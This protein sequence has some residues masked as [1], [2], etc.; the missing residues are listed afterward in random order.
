MLVEGINQFLIACT[1]VVQLLGAPQGRRD[2]TTGFFPGSAPE[3][4]P[5][6]LIVYRE[7]S[8][9]GE[10][11]FD[12]PDGLRYARVELSCQAAS[13]LASKQLGRAVRDALESFT[14]LLPDGTPVQNMER[15]GEMDT[16]EE[17]PFVYVTP[18]EF[19][20]AYSDL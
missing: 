14:G 13:Y 3:G 2:K 4:S 12:G 20:V 5:L 15:T 10:M 9:E 11:T 16:F 19:N 18:V 17:A 6:P 8:G 7:I 1:P